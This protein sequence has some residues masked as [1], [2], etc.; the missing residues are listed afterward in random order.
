M[1]CDSTL[2]AD[3]ELRSGDDPG[4]LAS[5]GLSI[6]R[7]GRS[8]H[9]FSQPCPCFDGKLCKIYS[10]RPKRCRLFECRLL[11]EVAAGEM[12]TGAALGKISEA[13]AL[14]GRVRRLVES[15]GQPFES[16][17]LAKCYGRSME[18]AIDLADETDA[19]RRG[20][21]MLAYGE[22]MQFVQRNFLTTS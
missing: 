19:E 16:L 8:K 14:A 2:F 10:S 20:E 1:C 4:R 17:A 5:L 12:T 3:V 22:L 18:K 15:L 7:K 13:R 11:A 21:L 9:A 6:A